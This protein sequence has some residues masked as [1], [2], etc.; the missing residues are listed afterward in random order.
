MAILTKVK[1]KKGYIKKYPVIFFSRLFSFISK[2]EYYIFYGS[3]DGYCDGHD[4][5][6][7]GCQKKC[8]VLLFAHL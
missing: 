3:R 5:N 4:H 2:V 1:K 8:I 6:K 7:N